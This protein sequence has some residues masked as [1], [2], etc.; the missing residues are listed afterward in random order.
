MKTTSSFLLAG[1]L[2]LSG[3]AGSDLDGSQPTECYPGDKDCNDAAGG[4]AEEWDSVNDPQRLSQNLDYVLANLPMTGKAS[5]DPWAAS[6]WPTVQGSTNY[7]WQGESVLSPLEKFDAAFHN[8]TPDAQY[9]TDVPAD[10]GPDAA[11]EYSAYVASLG[12]AAAWQAT[13][14]NRHLLFNGN[15]DDPDEDDDI[16]ECPE[17]LESWWGLCH[18]WAPA[19]ILEPEPLNPVDYNGQ[20]FEVSDIKALI[21][22]VY[23]DTQ[24]LM[25]GGR[26][27]AQTIEHDDTGRATANE[28]R[29]TNAGAWHVV[30]TNFLGVNGQGFVEDRTGGYQVWNQ[31]LYSYEVTMLEEIDVARANELLSVEGDEY[32]YNADVAKLFE[33]KMSTKYLTE[34]HQ[35]TQ[36]LGTQGYLRSDYYHYILEVDANGKV[37]GGEWVGSSVDNHPDFL[38]VPVRANTSSWRRSNPNIELSQ[39]RELIEL[40]R[41]GGGDGPIE[42]DSYSN[43]TTVEIPD[44]DPA[45]AT[46]VVTVGDQFTVAG[47]SV[48]VDITHTYVGDLVVTLEKDGTVITLQD[49]D[50]GSA[51]D[52]VKT[53]TVGDFDGAQAAGAWTLRV[54]DTANADTGAINKVTLTFQR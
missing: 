32:I 2:A 22:T 4:K 33:V 36:P 50:G 12:P 1:A 3:C 26:C 45:G 10:C 17:V 38:W 23:D 46:S 5:K 30:V 48:S 20:R 15:N 9:A 42:G 28:C 47:L 44:N 39:V 13:A 8:W 16:D 51:N 35:S 7:R 31:P 25:L 24:S 43:D 18:A 19:A 41:N 37:A 53:F 52:L 14:Q 11:T 34:G 27:N 29:D 40:S 54:V 21:L 49:R 6:Y